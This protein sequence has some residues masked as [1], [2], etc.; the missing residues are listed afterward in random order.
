M[1]SEKE[2]S[3]AEAQRA[4]EMQGL[5]QDAL[6]Q[7]SCLNGLE[8]H[9]SFLGRAEAEHPRRTAVNICPDQ[10]TDGN[11][12]RIKM[13]EHQGVNSPAAGRIATGEKKLGAAHHSVQ[14][15]DIDVHGPGTV[16]TAGQSDANVVRCDSAWARVRKN[17]S[18]AAGAL[19]ASGVRIESQT[20]NDGYGK[21]R[22]RA[23]EG[24]V[25]A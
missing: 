25:V 15:N 4:A 24:S 1:V 8:H 17:D 5:F 9:V 3:I 11:G 7:N 13:S 22:V 2:D 6:A 12:C 20:V 21:T 18:A 10:A 23:R 16:A 19:K 14:R